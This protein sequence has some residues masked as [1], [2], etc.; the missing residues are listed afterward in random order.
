MKRR[1]TLDEKIDRECLVS[2]LL[3]LEIKKSKIVEFCIDYTGWGVGK[4]QVYRY[5]YRAQMVN[6]LIDTMGTGKDKT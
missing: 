3:R 6:E 2:G 1:A 5:I 4:R